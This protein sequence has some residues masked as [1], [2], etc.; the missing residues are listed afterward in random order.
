MNEWR[1]PADRTVEM[2]VAMGFADL[3]DLYSGDGER[4]R[5]ALGTE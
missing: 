2:A 3:D 1:G 4:P 5:L